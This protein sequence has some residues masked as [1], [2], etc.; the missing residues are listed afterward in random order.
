MV[1]LGHLPPRG[2]SL[3][4]PVPPEE[5]GIE[6]PVPHLPGPLIQPYTSTTTVRAL[7]PR[8]SGIP[9]QSRSQSRAPSAPR[10]GSACGSC[11]CGAGAVPCPL[12]ARGAATRAGYALGSC[13]AGAGPHGG[14]VCGWGAG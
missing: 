1:H 3:F 9:S 13:A 4:P 5:H 8:G 6:V 14:P 11:A 7:P 10:A 2:T 12:A